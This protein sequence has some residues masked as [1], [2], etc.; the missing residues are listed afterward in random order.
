MLFHSSREVNA[1]AIQNLEA[2]IQHAGDTIHLKRLRNSLLNVSIFLPP[3]ILAHIFWW[4]VVSGLNPSGRISGGTFSFLLVCRYWFDVATSTPSLWAFWGPSLRQCTVFHPY[5]GA[6]P[7]HLNLTN[8]SSDREVKSPSCVLRDWNV[9][10]RIRHLDIH[11]T[12]R[13]LAEILS[14]M[15]TPQPSSV[16]SQIQSLTLAVEGLWDP[17]HPGEFPDIT[18]FL[19]ARFPSELRILHIRGCALGWES[20]ILCTS[21][22]T[23]LFIHAPNGSTK[24]TVLQLA[25]LFAGNSALEEID[26][27][28]EIISTPEG[29]LSRTPTSI[30]LPH[31]RRLTVRGSVTGHTRLLNRLTFSDALK[32]VNTDLFLDGIM[33]DVP[34]A[35]AP[36]LQ[37]LFLACQP[38]QLAI[39]ILY[40]S[41]GLDINLSRPGERGDPE[42][43][44]MLKMS[45][46]DVPLW[47]LVS[48]LPEEV[49]SRLPTTSITSLR[50]RRHSSVYRQDFRRLF[51]MLS[52]VQE[53]RITHSDIHDIV[54][55]LASPSPTGEDDEPALLPRLHTFQL[56]EIDFTSSLHFDTA[57]HLGHF[58]EQRCRD[59]LPLGRLSMV[60]CPHISLDACSGFAGS[61][62]DHFCWDRHEAA[63]A[64][65]LV[66]ETC[67]TGWGDL[68]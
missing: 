9:Q 49:V 53:L 56:R 44:L 59:G 23:H 37:N 3:E 16:R 17:G 28:L 26:L 25:A 42:D 32:Q 47:D 40:A 60:Y 5:S 52:S 2:K 6:V 10:R 46:R 39:H 64:R 29:S 55:V 24:P 48:S 21:K 67:H 8:V 62:S 43:F 33:M 35:L 7:L 18:D 14:L 61:L 38:S 31:L 4:T 66:C 58:L 22:L 65:Q 54:Q 45:S 27:S 36:F 19:G 30:F 15:S 34:A 20:L 13:I 57:T 68:D 50:I 63:S 12:P 41:A 51:R 11:T 1:P